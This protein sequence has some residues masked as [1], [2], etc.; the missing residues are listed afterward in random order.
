[1]SLIGGKRAPGFLPALSRAVSRVLAERG[2]VAAEALL[3][4]LRVRFA[5]R[6]NGSRWIL[7]EKL[8]ELEH[9]RAGT[10]AATSTAATAARAEARSLSGLL[11]RRTEQAPRPDLGKAVAEL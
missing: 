1:L 8:D 11:G 5:T 3:G 7:A 4:V 2:T 9:R 6:D 10:A